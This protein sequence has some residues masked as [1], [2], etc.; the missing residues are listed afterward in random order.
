MAVMNVLLLFNGKFDNDLVT[1]YGSL[2]IAIKVV[3]TAGD[4]KLLAHD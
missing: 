4:L 2:I 3:I 1:H